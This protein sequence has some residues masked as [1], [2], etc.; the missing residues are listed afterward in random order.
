[1]PRRSVPLNRALSKLEHEFVAHPAF[2]QGAEIN[3]HQGE[4]IAP[5]GGGHF[6]SHPADEVAPFATQ[7]KRLRDRLPADVGLV[8]SQWRE[9]RESSGE[10]APLGE[11]EAAE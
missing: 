6:A 2:A 10:I 5:D 4:V 3:G 9:N 7:P 1:M 8:V 11:G